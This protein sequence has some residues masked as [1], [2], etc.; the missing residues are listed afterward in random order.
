MT[1]QQHGRG[2]DQHAPVVLPHLTASASRYVNRKVRSV[3]GTT[4][5]GWQTRAWQLYHAIPEVRFAV[6]YMANGMAGATL[7]AGRRADGQ[8]MPCGLEMP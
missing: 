7:Y 6:T 1:V 8:R 3:K 4:D 5:S 2:L